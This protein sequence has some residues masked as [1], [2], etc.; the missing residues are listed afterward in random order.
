MLNLIC[1][2]CIFVQ[3]IAIEIAFDLSGA[4][5]RFVWL[6]RQTEVPTLGGQN[7]IL[8]A[9]DFSDFF[10][11]SPEQERLLR[12]NNEQAFKLLTH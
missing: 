2:S 11:S 3:Q 7:F 5:W 1:I 10:L 9:M 12:G 8:F 4:S 6:T